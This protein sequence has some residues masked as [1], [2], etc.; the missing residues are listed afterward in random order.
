M[1]PSLLSAVA[2]VALAATASNAAVADVSAGV[3]HTPRMH[4]ASGAS[5]PIAD[6]WRPNATRYRQRLNQQKLH[7]L[8]NAQQQAQLLA[9]NATPLSCTLAPRTDFER[10]CCLRHP[11]SPT[12]GDIRAL[13]FAQNCSWASGCCARHRKSL[14]C[15]LSP[16]NPSA[17]MLLARHRARRAGHRHAPSRHRHNKVGASAKLIDDERSRRRWIKF[18]MAASAIPLLALCILC[19]KSTR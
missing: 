16:E 13:A 4:T 2:A 17:E 15:V 1:A 14:A 12:C 7:R 19:T 9:A 11:T 3:E 18:G 8:I 5:W 6:E 10:R